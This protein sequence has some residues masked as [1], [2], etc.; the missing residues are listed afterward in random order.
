MANFNNRTQPAAAW[1]QLQQLVDSSHEVNIILLTDGSY[2]VGIDGGKPFIGRGLKETVSE[3]YRKTLRRPTGQ[4][5][6]GDAVGKLG[7]N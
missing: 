3:A 4:G 5:T 7:S 1:S 6:T 2:R